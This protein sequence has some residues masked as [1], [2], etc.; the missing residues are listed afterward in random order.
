MKTLQDIKKEIEANQ[1]AKRA[2]DAERENAN[3]AFISAHKAHDRDAAGLASL[4]IEKLKK[5][6]ERISAR[7]K[8]L[9]NNYNY[10]LVETGK[11]AL[12]E[13][14]KKYDGKKHGEKT[15]E[16]IRDEMRARGYAFYFP[17]THYFSQEKDCI[18]INE[19]GAYGRG[20]EIWTKNRAKI[21]DENNT[22]HAEAVAEVVAP[23]KY[24]DNVEKYLDK[25][26]RLTA[27]T[28]KAFDVASAKAHELNEIAVEG[29]GWRA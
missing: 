23:Y 18:N 21:V 15:A 27:E 22:L 7:G 13:I 29:L 16:K 6:A 17:A 28:R 10:I 19:R 2:N 24:I 5:A 4:E 8:V 20:L 3:T 14:L 26:E 11:T 25:I 1:E 12:A 9:T